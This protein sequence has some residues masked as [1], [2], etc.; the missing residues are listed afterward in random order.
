[1]D[2]IT[3]E[4]VDAAVRLHKRL[5]PGLLESVY[6]LF[7]AKELY[8]RGLVVERRKRSRSTSME[9]GSITRSE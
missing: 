7:L 1:M 3:G 9:S 8:R 4:I 2:E 6:E 5:G